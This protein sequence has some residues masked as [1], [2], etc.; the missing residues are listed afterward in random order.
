MR[1]QAVN[2]LF[3]VLAQRTDFLAKAKRILFFRALVSPHL[4]E[5]K[6]RD[7]TCVQ[8]F[9]P[10]ELELAALGL[11]T[12]A[13]PQ[14]EY[15]LI[16]YLPTNQRVE[17]LY[18]F[19]YLSQ[20]LSQGGRLVCCMSNKIGAPRFQKHLAEL[21]GEV[22]AESKNHY[23]V[24]WGVKKDGLN[25]EVFN[26]WIKLGG[27][28]EIQAG[29]FVSQPGI[30]GWEKIDLGSKLLVEN[31]PK[32]LPGRGADLGAGYGYISHHLVHNVTG[33]KALHLY[34]AENLALDAARENLKNTNGI[35]L[36]FEW[37]DVPL[38]LK[39]RDLDWIVMNPPFH[40][41][42]VNSIGVGYKFLKAAKGSLRPGGELYLVANSHL[43]YREA[44]KSD[45]GG[46]DLLAQANGFTVY[47]AAR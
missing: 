10:F 8:S 4:V 31:L 7:L 11:I 16:F 37:H 44:L 23:R 27:L 29:A 34:E 30:F 12:N 43:P 42:K 14:G 26:Q 35:E 41:G 3:E 20:F 2:I 24:F 25:Q 21:F 22:E 9:K 13:A 39:H 18:N 15:D 28:R 1:D 5:L 40:T 6:G 33:I 46:F 36:S 19:A 45:F 38:G 32:S 17:N 47:R